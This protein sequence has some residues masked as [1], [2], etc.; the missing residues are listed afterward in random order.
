MDAW[1]MAVWMDLWVDAWMMDECRH[2]WNKMNGWMGGWIDMDGWMDACMDG[3]VMD[4][5][6]D[7]WMEKWRMHGL[8]DETIDGRQ[9]QGCTN[10]ANETQTNT[11]I[12]DKQRRAHTQ[13]RTQWLVV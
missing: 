7:R 6:I 2:G 10:Q 1:T 5:C 12:G 3:W 8:M 13:L 11:H 4:A 9:D